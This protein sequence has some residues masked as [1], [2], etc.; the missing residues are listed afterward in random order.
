MADEAKWELLGTVDVDAGMLWIGDPCYVLHREEGL[1]STVG[2][3]WAAFCALTSD[4]RVTKFGHAGGEGE[5]LGL[6]V[7]TGYGDGTYPVFGRI[8]HGR[9]LE[10]HVV[11]AEPEDVRFAVGS[12][13]RDAFPV[14][15]DDAGAAG[16][17]A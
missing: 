4:S 6:A 2:K 12:F 3:D 9:V 11:F 15:V 10:L 5:G 17:E 13:A 8:E 14:I 1:P 16:E 7:G